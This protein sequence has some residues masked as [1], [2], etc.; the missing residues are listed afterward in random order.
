MAEVLLVGLHPDVVE[1]D[2]WPGLTAEKL[3]GA[4]EAD[5]AKLTE[6]SHT[7]E[8]FWVKDLATAA[9]DLGAKLAAGS[10]GVVLIGAGVRTDADHF[11]LF[12]KLINAIHTNAPSAR[13]AFNSG[14]TDTADA[15]L[16]WV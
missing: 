6:A 14:P 12:E 9:D 8:M 4:M 7:A 13:I 2:K 3:V 15:V 1:F 11:L 10:Y 5:T 16:R